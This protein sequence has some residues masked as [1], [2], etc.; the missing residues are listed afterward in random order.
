VG[1]V[2]ELSIVMNQETG[3]NQ[4][5]RMLI[6]AVTMAALA[7]SPFA[8]I[9]QDPDGY[10]FGSPE[11]YEVWERTDLPVELHQV[12]RTWM[13]G[14]G[15]NTQMITEEYA[16]G[17][18][19]TRQVQY[20]DKSRME[21]PV[22]TVAPDSDWFITQGLLATE[23]MT[24]NLQ[25]GH[26]TFEQ[27][28]AADIYV[29]G[30]P[31]NNESPTYAQMGELMDDPARPTGGTI[32]QG[33]TSDSSVVDMPN[34][35]QY[36]VTD[37][38]YIEQTD[39]NIA[40][41]FWDFMNSTGVV[42]EDGVFR[43]GDVFTNPFYAIG[44][45]R[46]EAFWGNVTVAE[47]PQ[48]VLIQCFER[49]CLTYAPG[50][51]PGW[52]VESG[53][54]G[55]HYYDWRYEHI[56]DPVDDHPPAED[57]TPPA[58]DDMP[59]VDDGVTDDDEPVDITMTV[60]PQISSNPYMG[61]GE[62]L[63]IGQLLTMTNAAVD[64]GI[65]I[66]WEEVEQE[67]QQRDLVEG[68]PMPWDDILDDVHDDISEITTI[69]NALDDA[70][71]NHHTVTVSVQASGSGATGTA[72]VEI[73]HANQGGATS[74]V[75]TETFS[76]SGSTTSHQVRYESSGPGF[77]SVEVTVDGD[78]ESFTDVNEW[79]EQPVS[80]DAMLSLSPSSAD[81]NLVGEEH[82]VEA[83]LTES[84]GATPIGGAML[85]MDIISGPNM[86]LADSVFEI[87]NAS[88]MVSLTYTGVGGEGDDIVGASATYLTSDGN[89]AQ[90]GTAPD[91][92]ASVEWVA[93]QTT[94][95]YTGDQGDDLRRI[96]GDGNQSWI[97]EGHSDHVRVVA[98]DPDGY[99]YSG[100]G[101]SNG[102][103]KIDSDGELVWSYHG[104]DTNSFPNIS[105]IAVDR[106][107]N[108]YGGSL[109]SEE[110]H[111]IDSSGNLE[112]IY[113]GHDEPIYGI[114]ADS[115]GTIY[116]SSDDGEVHKV[117]SSG[118]LITAYPGIGDRVHTLAIDNDGNLHTSTAYGV[119]RKYD[120]Q[121]NML[122]QRTSSDGWIGEIAIDQHGN[123]YFTDDRLHK[124]NSGGNLV[125]TFDSPDTD[126][127]GPVA[128][129]PAGYVYTGGHDGT[130]YKI[131]SDGN[132]VW[133]F[134]GDDRNIQ[135]LAVD[136]GLY[137]AFPDEWE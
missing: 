31:V 103:H 127:F 57:D 14:P 112:W 79:I 120:S 28:Q 23:L 13:W 59:G 92:N 105:S 17:E 58:T 41:V 47:Q 18:G 48:E 132:Q 115:E 66:D 95:I 63:L 86:T 89:F 61:Q 6:V 109:R 4:K 99:I 116:V 100:S 12:S 5:A 131:D 16:E 8:A 40:S 98:V 53:N 10:D 29:A 43:Q 87:T 78:T 50:N 110:V 69:I 137:G 83:T 118:Q 37:A 39:N 107:G 75:H 54:I 36:G 133:T 125:W 45:P 2:P 15:A 46:T 106:D 67:I 77:D 101:G 33:L 134:Q 124:L 84:D 60:S 76:Y 22:D 19:G 62:G 26:D 119:L 114:A 135:S 90:V 70:D 38:H 121:G 20:T 97:Y 42:F 117:N 111:K 126:W 72:N 96:D 44:F 73:S 52:E 3:M 88:G 82:T 93:G 130:V 113:D 128:V 136:P 1:F 51:V 64:A 32:T 49:R 21:L 11:F 85:N 102:I 65:E 104:F 123:V 35:A 34:T 129:D 55:Q 91:E 74:T 7:I 30:D 25:L 71:L 80:G 9:G 27:Y 68:D 108:V 81:G 56:D 94:Y 24:G 122:W